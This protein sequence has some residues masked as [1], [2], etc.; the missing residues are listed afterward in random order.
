VTQ[1]LRNYVTPRVGNYVTR[2]ARKLR[3]FMTAHNSELQHKAPLSVV[4]RHAHP[5]RTGTPWPFKSA[6]ACPRP[7]TINA[8][9]STRSP[10]PCSQPMSEAISRKA[11]TS[12]WSE[13]HNDTAAH[14]VNCGASPELR[15]GRRPARTS[16]FQS[17]AEQPLQVMLGVTLRVSGNGSNVLT[18]RS[19]GLRDLPLLTRSAMIQIA[20][21]LR[22]F[23]LIRTLATFYRCT[24]IVQRSLARLRD[25]LMASSCASTATDGKGKNDSNY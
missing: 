15:R 24:D 23:R 6:A 8:G 21:S 12:A 11:E 1:H 2:S 7:S 4:E 5:S 18:H 17:I 3:N 16:H 25:R 14:E 13:A 19:H 9:P 22:Y 10:A 20:A